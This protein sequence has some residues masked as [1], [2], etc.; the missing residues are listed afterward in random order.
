VIRATAKGEVSHLAKLA[1]FPG[2]YA[3]VGAAATAGGGARTTVMRNQNGVVIE[4]QNT[5]QGA[6]LRLGSEGVRLT[7]VK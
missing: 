7:L 3:A 5:T 6:S 4:L 2:S 1:D